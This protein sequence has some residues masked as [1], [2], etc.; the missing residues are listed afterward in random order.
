MINQV[1]MADNKT[2]HGESWQLINTITGR[3]SAKRGI[4]KG[5]MKEEPM[6]RTLQQ[7]P[8]QGTCITRRSP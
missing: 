4:I 8:R 5:N 3:K 1:E 2:K 6:V 7:P